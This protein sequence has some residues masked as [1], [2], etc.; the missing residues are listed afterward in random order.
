MNNKKEIKQAYS[1]QFPPTL[2]ITANCLNAQNV[3][4]DLTIFG[5]VK[6]RV[7]KQAIQP[8]VMVWI[9]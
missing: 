4:E 3:N 6:V 5:Q 9:K 2:F 8:F 7:G 1:G